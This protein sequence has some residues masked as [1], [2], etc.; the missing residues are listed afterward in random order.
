MSKPLPFRSDIKTYNTDNYVNVYAAIK[1]TTRK[2]IV[3]D[4]AQYLM[5]NEY[6]ERAKETG[7]QKFTDIGKH[8]Y[9]LLMN[10]RELPEDTIVY[11]L[12]HTQTDES[13]KERFKTVGKLMDNYSIEGVC[14]ICLKTMVDNG[15]WF[16]TE[17]N[18]QDTVKAPLAMFPESK[19]ENDLKKVDEII[20]NYYGFNNDKKETKSK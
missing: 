3:I 4:D 2:I 11:L 8:F 14:T 20:R 16:S 5:I 19:I 17:N 1:K 7:Y 18:G 10:I 6:M 12:A 15:Y 9:D 13:G